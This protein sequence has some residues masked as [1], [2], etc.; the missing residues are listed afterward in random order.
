MLQ[1]QL[2][3]NYHLFF[4]Y[5]IYFYLPK[6]NFLS[7]NIMHLLFI[8]SLL[9]TIRSDFIISFNLKNKKFVFEYLTNL[10]YQA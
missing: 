5:H 1:Y 9:S 4:L 7:K 10:H 8:V 3:K 2:Y 6:Q